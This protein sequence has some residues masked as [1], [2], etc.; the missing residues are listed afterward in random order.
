[1]ERYRRLASD[2]YASIQRFQQADADNRKALAA[3]GKARAALA[4]AQRRL[5][6]IDTQKQETRVA[7]AQ[8]IADR[9]MA[10]LNLGFTE[11]RAPIDG[12]V[13]NRNARVGAYAMVGAPL[14]SLV[15]ARGLWVDANFKESQ[16]GH[17]RPGLPASIEADVLPEQVFHLAAGSPKTTLG[18]GCSSSISYPDHLSPLRC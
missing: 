12:M 16:L 4:A 6:V 9:D 10:Q 18:T 17:Y 15:P 3:A 13:G 1:V 11:L 14:I 7:L 5:D 2:Q 8:A